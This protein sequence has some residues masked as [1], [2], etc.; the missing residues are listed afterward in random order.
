VGGYR[1]PARRE[2]TRNRLLVLLC[3]YVNLCFRLVAYIARVS[4][5]EMGE[6][7]G[8]PSHCVGATSKHAGR[9]NTALYIESVR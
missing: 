4:R 6:A 9:G 8:V 5:R 3:L 2:D 1:F 7:L